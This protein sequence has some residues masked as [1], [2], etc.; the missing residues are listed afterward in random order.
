VHRSPSVALRLSYVSYVCCALPALALAQD[1]EAATDP[2]TP[3]AAFAEHFGPGPEQLCP[4]PKP[5][6]LLDAAQVGALA[7]PAPNAAGQRAAIDALHA[8]AQRAQ[9]EPLW[10]GVFAGHVEAL[11]EDFA[12]SRCEEEWQVGFTRVH[13]SNE[14]VAD[15]C[16]CTFVAGSAGEP[17]HACYRFSPPA[18]PAACDPQGMQVY[19]LPNWAAAARALVLLRMTH[20]ALLDLSEKCR[21]LVVT[22]L[23][24]AEKRWS[25][26]IR[27]GYVQ[28]PWEL[29]FSRLVSSDY[30]DYSRCFAAD[31][32]CTGEEGL[33]PETLRPIFL[34]PGV[35][36][37]FPGFGKDDDEPSAKGEFV[38]LLE[39]IGATLYDRDFEHYLGLS[40]IVGFQQADF[41]RPRV[42]LLVHLSRYLQVGYLYGLVE[43][44]AHNG[45][46][47]LSVDILGWSN[48]SLGLLEPAP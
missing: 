28:Y 41:A 24:V 22:R 18:E 39:A 1:A 12:P 16:G 44:T 7:Q 6:T 46:L 19:E 37:G 21:E 20:G 45:T 38:I 27:E 29:W 8:L 36:L 17:G 25:R 31:A 13:A 48:R 40:A 33:D 30:G 15:A 47:Y 11:L 32:S 4:L 9:G 23:T 10:G 2:C 43:E 42:G 3:R 5:T 35:G 26:L 14:P 34:H